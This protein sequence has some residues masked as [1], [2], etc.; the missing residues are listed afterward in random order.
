MFNN[1]IETN[2][3]RPARARQF[4]LSIAIHTALIGAAVYGTLQATE[5]PERPKA[6]DL[7]FAATPIERPPETQPTPPPDAIAVP[8]MPKGFQVLI[9]PVK[10]PDRLPGIDLTRPVTDPGDFTGIGVPGGLGRG[11]AAAPTQETFQA[12]EVEKA[13]APVPGAAPRYPDMLRTANVEGQVLAQFVVDTA[14]RVDITTFRVL[15][16]THDLFTQAVRQHLATARFF[17]AEIGGRRVKQLVQQPFN[18][19]LTR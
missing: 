16:S 12:F 6:E 11:I 13:V 14:G 15:S 9:P 7:H 5:P 3:R 17:P 8:S 2:P 1:L 19:A 18:F 4:A 10:I